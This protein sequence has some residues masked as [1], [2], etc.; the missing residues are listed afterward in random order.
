DHQSR[1][2]RPGPQPLPGGPAVAR[3]PTPAAGGQA[4]RIAAVCLALAAVASADGLA[5]GDAAVEKL[6]ACS[7][8]P[9]A[10]RL[11]C[12]D[13]L[14]RDPGPPPTDPKTKAKQVAPSAAD[15]VVSETTSPFDY[16]PIAIA[17]ATANGGPDNVAV[18]LSIQCRG[19][20]TDLVVLS[21][22]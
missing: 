1:C 19:G 6:R 14:S 8:M 16:S 21:P 5:Q 9:R 13:K 11:E 15:W 7:A 3:P 17:T 12:L 10:E 20:R 2:D 18:Q 4:M 22:V